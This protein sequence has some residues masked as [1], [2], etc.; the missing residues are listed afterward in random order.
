MSNDV[1][2]DDSARNDGSTEVEI[3]EVQVVTSSNDDAPRP[4]MMVEIIDSSSAEGANDPPEVSVSVVSEP[5]AVEQVTEPV[6]V[7]PV[8]VEPVSEPAVAEQVSEPV[9]VEEPVASKSGEQAKSESVSEAVAA[10]E[11]S[12]EPAATETNA[13]PEA[14]QP[15]EAE[16][17]EETNPF[18][19]MGLS[20]AVLE[21]IEKSG[22]KTPSEIQA[23][24]IPIVLA[25][26]D[27]IGQAETGSGKTAAFALP[28][29]S[30]IDLDAKRPQILVL[31]PTRELA[32]QVTASFDKYAARIKGYRSVC[33]YG[34]QSYEA[35]I[36]ALQRG[37]Q[38]VVGT[39]GRVMDHIR[40]ETL[41]LGALKTFVLDEADEMLRM[42][43][44]DDIEWILEHIPRERQTVMF[45]ATM[46]D[47]IRRIARQHLRN[48][49]HITIQSKSAT[50][51]SINQQLMFVHPRD[52]AETLDRLLQS[53][54]PDGVLVFSKTRS[55]TIVVS[56]FLTQR[57]Y[58]VSALNGDMQQSQ[59]ERTVNQLKSGRIDI[60]VAT[61]VAARGLDVERISHVINYDFPHDTEAYVHRIGR[62]GRAGREGNAILFVEPKEKGKL[63][64][65]QRATN[66]R[67]DQLREKSLDEINDLR[68]E[69]FLQK[70]TESTKNAEIAMFTKIL[71]RYQKQT[72]TPIEEV[73]AALAVMAQGKTPLIMKEL[74][75][76]RPS[77]DDSR[78]NGRDRGPR[79]DN[80]EMTTYRVEV[81][82][83]HGVGAGNLVGAITNEGNLSSSDIGR[84]K[85]FDDFSLVD[86]PK[87]LP[88]ATVSHLE[89]VYVANRTL[90]IKEDSGG[91]GGGGGRRF[92]RGGGSGYKKKNNG[93][94]RFGKRFEKKSGGSDRGAS[95]SRSG[96]SSSG[97]GYK[98]KPRSGSGGGY[99]SGARSEGGG[100]YKS[101]PRSEGGGGYKSSSRSEGGYKSSSRSEGGSTSSGGYGGERKSYGSSS[102]PSSGG[103]SKFSAKQAKRASKRKG[104]PSADAPAKKYVKIRSSK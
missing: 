29:L 57:G 90:Q 32:I 70:I 92:E 13:E 15:A 65:L 52:K 85:L 71:A 53:E 51:D 74:K 30:K 43:F 22:Y 77:R 1:S 78:G 33:I 38:V 20:P 49:K 84:I 97:G 93:S 3:S 55:T 60:V 56:E 75:R 45:S 99:K 10:S 25:N 14:A 39:P 8:A 11:E 100:G 44:V 73:A 79:R 9:V 12:S 27:L 63:A 2:R 69:K 89:N 35:Q 86:L 101:S 23:E 26:L 6:A 24:T 41:D 18:E 82:K 54:E 47:D 66:Q 68:V 28:L 5:V 34:G 98:G 88:S 103:K 61:D 81:G 80:S 87:D 37:V 67:I 17:V 62:T 50:A 102:K 19:E 42:G 96:G 94:T 72:E 4:S 64:R 16:M 83:S 104:G 46:P 7:E 31:A 59:R 48:P 40:R 36:R 76:G 91:G 95:G 58:R 21:A